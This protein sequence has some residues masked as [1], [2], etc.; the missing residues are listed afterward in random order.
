MVRVF[1]LWIPG[2][3]QSNDKNNT[4]LCPAMAARENTFFINEFLRASC[5]PLR[6]EMQEDGV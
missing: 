5:Y 4:R 1:T 6:G 3:Q 2:E